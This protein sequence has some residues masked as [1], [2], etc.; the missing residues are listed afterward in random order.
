LA[1]AAATV[2]MALAV[3][4]TIASGAALQAPNGRP[5]KPATSP[6]GALPATPPSAVPASWQPIGLPAG[7]RA[8]ALSCPAA[9]VCVLLGV[10]GGTQTVEE[11]DAGSWTAAS[12]PATGHFNVNGLTCVTEED[13]WAVGTVGQPGGSDGSSTSPA[14]ARNSGAGFQLVPSPPM[15][16]DDSLSAVA[17]VDADDCW[18]VGSTGSLGGFVT[19]PASGPSCDDNGVITV[20]PVYVDVVVGQPLAEH[21]DGTAWTAVTV[22]SPP[23]ANLWLTGVSCLSAADCWAIG[24][25]VS[26]SS[27][28]IES[29]VQGYALEHYDGGS[30]TQVDTPAV[31]GGDD[32]SLDS[33][34]CV[35]ADDC[36]AVGGYGP[37][38]TAGGP[39]PQPV[40]EHDTGGGWMLVASPEITAPNGGSLSSLACLSADDC[41][42]LGFA[43]GPGWDQMGTPPPP[44]YWGQNV[45]EHYDGQSWS[46][47]PSLELSMNTG[48]LGSITCPASGDCYAIGSGPAQGVE[49]SSQGLFLA[50]TPA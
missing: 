48:T 47:V 34:T 5:A 27:P 43:A 36:W 41:W 20:C 35:T 46:R 31:G 18:A 21:Y 42:A 17:C 12:L 7:F 6:T 37:M 3:G 2:V 40:I 30:W 14:I 50:L 4:V 38:H 29:D 32:S 10:I 25:E 23:S 8:T 1:R 15:S 49:P 39:L 13:C 45:V 26:V 16:G 28:G 19:M 24:K 11:Y 22:P 33:L 44:T 9:G